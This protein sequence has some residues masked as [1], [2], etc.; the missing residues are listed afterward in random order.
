MKKVDV[1]LSARPNAL[2]L[3]YFGQLA[4]HLLVVENVHSFFPWMSA[5][6]S[7]S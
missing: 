7:S 2:A 3:V 6:S 1:T 5:T 4:R